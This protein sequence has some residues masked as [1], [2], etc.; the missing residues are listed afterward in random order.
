MSDAPKPDDG[1]PCFICRRAAKVDNTNFC[2]EC[3]KLFG[4]PEDETLE[5]C[6][7]IADKMKR[8]PQ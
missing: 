5:A 1:Q 4:R 8:R 3:G 7:Q 6:L 2:A